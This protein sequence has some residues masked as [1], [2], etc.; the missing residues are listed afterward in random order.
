MKSLFVIGMLLLFGQAC[1]AQLLQVNVKYV[2]QAKGMNGSDNIFYA[3]GNKLN[4]NDFK[5]SPDETDGAVALT[6]SGFGYGA[7]FSA[8]GTTSTLLIE[9]Y[10]NFDKTKSWCKEKGRNPSVLNH[11]QR[12]FDISFYHTLLFIEKLRSAVFS[13]KG[14]KKEIAAIYTE[15][16]NSL[17]RMQNQYDKET[18]NGM[19]QPAQEK[20]SNSLDSRISEKLTDTP[21]TN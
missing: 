6:Y 17:N 13:V 9:V 3:P 20:W 2:L 8:N 12:H 4:L 14:F 5:A 1:C 11:E 16:G 15:C 7:R 19:N 21:L 18:S 10:C